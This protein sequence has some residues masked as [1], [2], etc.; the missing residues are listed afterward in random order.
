M[1]NKVLIPNWIQRIPIERLGLLL[2]TIARNADNLDF[3]ASAGRLQQLHTA[4][5]M[6][7][8]MLL[9]MMG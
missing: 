2:G 8:I 7:M 9:L 4:I 1:E 5:P 3:N 6:S